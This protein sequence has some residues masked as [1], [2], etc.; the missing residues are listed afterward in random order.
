[1]SGEMSNELERIARGG[2]LSLFGLVASALFA[3]LTRTIVG[4]AFGPAQYG[5]YSLSLTVFSIALIIAMFGLPTGLPRQ[6]SY[7]AH[8]KRERVNDLISTTAILALITSTMTMLMLF[9]L[10]GFLADLLTTSPPGKELLQRLLSIIALGLPFAALTNVLIA[11]AQGY[12][13]VREYIYYGKIGFPALYLILATASTFIIGDLRA[14]MVSYV[15][16]YTFILALLSRD[17]R[18]AGILPD[19]LKFSSDLVKEI[20]LF[21][22][23]LLTSNI[24]SMVM[25]WTDSLMLGHF[26]GNR[27]VGIYTA[28]SPLAR[29]IAMTVMALMTIYTPVVTGFFAEGRLDLVRRFYSI[30]TKWSILLMFPLLFLFLDYPTQLVGAFFGAS[31]TEAARPLVILSL[32]FAFVAAGGPAVHTLIT[33]G[34]TLDN[35]KG[36]L[37]GASLNVLL[38]YILIES[39]GMIGAAL[40]TFTSYVVTVSYKLTLLIRSG[41]MPYNRRHFLLMIDAA[42]VLLAFRFVSVCGLLEALAVTIL[43]SA[44]FY[45]VAILVGVP[46]EEDLMLLRKAGKKYGIPVEWL[47]RLLERKL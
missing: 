13:R 1:M 39:F 16:S 33:M 46:E 41:V 4:R 21:S 24:I 36:D 32:G 37:I 3:F 11:V 14:V 27:V 9:P 17:L 47:V 40:A 35:M 15:V 28:A 43:A 45:G 8:R 5:S 25:T 6:V 23:P 38:N 20:V 29:F 19:R 44:V 30:M 34:K 7:F 18:R 10:T 42:A 12:K 26:L 2:F 22:I 31:Y